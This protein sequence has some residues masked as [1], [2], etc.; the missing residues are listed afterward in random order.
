MF[1]FRID[2]QGG[3]KATTQHLPSHEDDFYIARVA[4]SHSKRKMSSYLGV[5]VRYW[6]PLSTTTD[7]GAYIGPSLFLEIP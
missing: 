6:M 2:A 4:L 5:A 1:T 7:S 3:S